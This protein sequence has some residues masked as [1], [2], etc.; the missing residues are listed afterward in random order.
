[1]EIFQGFI[2]DPILLLMVAAG[3]FFGILFGT[4]PGIGNLMAMSLALPLTYSLSPERG[5]LLLIGIYCGGI[6]GG[7]LTAI[8][9]RIPGSPENAAAMFDGYP[10]AQ[11]G[12]AD[13][14]IGA[15]VIS[16]VIGG[17][18]S[19]L[20]MI[21]ACSFIAKAALKF[22]PMEY[23]LLTIFAFC[24]IAT[25][26]GT[27]QLKGWISILFGLFLAIIGTS[28]IY[29]LPRFAFGSN[30]LLSG[31]DYVPVLIGVFAVSELIFRM[32]TS[33]QMSL[34]EESEIKHRLQ[35]PN[36]KELW[37]LKLTIFMSSI[38]GTFLGALPGIGATFA[39]FTGYAGAKKWS[40]HPERLGKGV[41]EG[42]MA[43]EAANNASTGGSMIPLITLGIPGSASTAI[44]LS[45]LMLHGLVP[46]PSFFFKQIDLVYTIYIGM[47]L[48]NVFI[49]IIAYFEIGHILKV[50]YIPFTILG[51]ILMSVCIIGS[52]ALSNRIFDV[53]IMIFFGMIGYIM[54][55]Y[56]YSIIGLTMGIILGAMLENHF[57]R[58]YLLYEDNFL[59]EL[60][61]RPI[62]LS[63]AIF[64]IVV[65]VVVPIKKKL[66]QK[67]LANVSE[68][69]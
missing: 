48:A 46:G 25:L 44:L 30:Y 28:Q 62:S 53:W 35:F 56:N 9:F 18:A 40:K 12:E 6:Y 10:M 22:G 15:A 60:F 19:V 17:I 47:I 64:T 1:M 66:S 3:A 13:K 20:L 37:D 34:K 51:P 33:K 67:R 23:F 31:V 59:H 63:F 26:G 8:L 52:F 55:R 38:L 65:F 61:S 16:S 42:I 45:T 7:S 69:F 39:S 27:S 5:I 50:M 41:I 43:P 49:F 32:G 54:K 36:L 11:R 58:M 29:G 68:K 24:I 2:N 21:F 4:I 14:A 57:Y